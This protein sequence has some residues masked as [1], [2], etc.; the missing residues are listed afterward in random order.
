MRW[1][2]LFDDLVAQL[3]R[4]LAAE[5]A[6]ERRDTAR[7]AVASVGHRQVL[8][9]VA[10]HVDGSVLI[11]TRARKL[12]VTVDTVGADWVAVTE[13]DPATSA[14]SA[15]HVMPTQAIT[16]IELA[17]GVSLASVM[18]RNAREELRPRLIDRV[19]FDVVLRD[20]ARRRR[21]VEIT[22]CDDVVAG[23]LDVV[24]RDWCEVARHPRHI[25]RRQSAIAGSVLIPLPAV[26][27][28]RVD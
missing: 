19:A 13:T 18:S 22:T 9:A 25:A 1:N 5:E 26:L 4:E 8:L 3:D 20:L 15:T 2:N 10:K 21:W 23:T 24:G 11:R 12:T 6:D 28:V 27:G 7:A 14:V 17:S 16:A